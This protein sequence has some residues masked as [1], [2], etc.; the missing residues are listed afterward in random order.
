MTTMKPLDI[1]DGKSARIARW[2]GETWDGACAAT[3]RRLEREHGL[4]YAAA[5]LVETGGDPR[6]VP[7]PAAVDAI[8]GIL[9]RAQGLDSV[10]IGTVLVMPEPPRCLVTWVPRRGKPTQV[11]GRFL[12]PDYTLNVT[13]ALRELLALPDDMT[14]NTDVTQ[15]LTAEYTRSVSVR[16]SHGELRVELWTE[17]PR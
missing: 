7:D 17:P 4:F 1:H 6:R 10:T 14:V 2:D 8:V 11:H 15:V 9:E 12:T 16:N 13:P 5:T 3:A